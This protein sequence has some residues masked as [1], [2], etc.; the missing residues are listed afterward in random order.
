MDEETMNEAASV[1]SAAPGIGE[2]PWPDL[3][4]APVLEITDE[5]AARER[6]MERLQRLEREQRGTLWNA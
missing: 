1:A 4:T 2:N 3:P 6:Q 5:V